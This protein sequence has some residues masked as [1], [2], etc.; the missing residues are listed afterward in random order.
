MCGLVGQPTDVSI[1]IITGCIMLLLQ[2]IVLYIHTQG[3]RINYCNTSYM[4]NYIIILF[5]LR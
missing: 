2:C 5:N 3:Q 1:V 4:H